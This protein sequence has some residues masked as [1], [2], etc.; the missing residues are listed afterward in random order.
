M[1]LNSRAAL[2][3]VLFALVACKGKEPAPAAAVSGTA[4]GSPSSSP[5][6]ASSGLAVLDGFEGE[7]SLTAKGKLAN[8][9]ESAAPASFTLLVKDGKFRFDVPQGLAGAQALGKAYVLA[10]PAD[11]KLYA[12]M[13]DKKQAV[14]VDLDQLAAQA[15]SFGGG[16]AAHAPSHGSPAKVEKTGKTDTVAGYKCE[17]WHIVSEKSAGDLCIAEQGTSW[18]HIP[19]SGVPAEYAWASEIT[20]G[21]HFPLRFVASENGV[22]QGR[23]EVTS[24]QK[25]ALPAEQV[26]VPA[27]YAVLNLEQMLGAMMGGMPGGMPGMP[28]GMPSGFVLPH[29]AFPGAHHPKAK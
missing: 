8:K 10:M 23:L 27:G 15:K 1:K 12:V 3:L 28:P 13:D 26:Q 17:I 24:I 29:G 9:A 6:A 4:L 19:L 20:D 14:L 2:P 16:A 25:K 5:A 22:E 21:K 11:K 18:F 7:I